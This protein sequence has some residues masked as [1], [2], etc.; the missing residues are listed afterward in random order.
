MPNFELSFHLMGPFNEENTKQ[1]F[2]R[3][4]NLLINV[5]SCSTHLNF[6][7]KK[8]TSSYSF[9]NHLANKSISLFSMLKDQ[10]TEIM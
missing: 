6:L 3:I 10:E 8:D 9:K 2:Q 1:N 7:L 4:F 5:V